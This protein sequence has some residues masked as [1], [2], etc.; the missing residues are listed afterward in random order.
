MSYGLMF[1]L[2]FFPSF[3]YVPCRLFLSALNTI[4]HKHTNFIQ[5][6][7]HK[8]AFW[9]ILLKIYLHTNTNNYIFCFNMLLLSDNYW[10]VTFITTNTQQQQQLQQQI[11]ISS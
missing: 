4:K 5:N 1:I 9:I 2:F 6:S 3:L 8:N 7:T 10:P 11:K